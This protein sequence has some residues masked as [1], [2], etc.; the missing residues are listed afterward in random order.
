MPA[1]PDAFVCGLCCRSA[2]S[3]LAGVLHDPMVQHDNAG[4]PAN[5]SS[6]PQPKKRRTVGQPRQND[7]KAPEPTIFLAR[8]YD[9]VNDTKT[10]M[11]IHWSTIGGA[12]A[13]T[14]VDNMLLEKQWLPKFYKHSNF[15]S[16]VR[17]LNQYQFRKVEPRRWSFAHESFIKNR[18]DLL[19]QITRKRKDNDSAKQNSSKRDE[20]VS[21]L[22]ACVKQLSET[23]SRVRE[24]QAEMQTQLK[25]LTEK[26]GGPST[27]Q[28]AEVK[29]QENEST[30]GMPPPDLG[31]S[32][33]NPQPG[34]V[35]FA[36]VDIP[37]DIDGFLS[38]AKQI[39]DE[40]PPPP[41]PPHQNQHQHQQ[42]QQQ[43]RRQNAPPPPAVRTAPREHPLQMP[44]PSTLFQASH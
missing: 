33:L 24:Q 41:P 36:D 30:M 44:R 26:I 13:F 8:L 18:P 37:A 5:G 27:G 19:V 43:Q 1:V 23:L 29:K 42:R 17:Q 11:A 6:E 15:T 14:I 32:L 4:G 2:F 7:K 12:S 40:Q 38:S 10:D 28:L 35:E 34:V 9:M 22:E 25:N 3:A 31:W 16:F 20:R 39:D 21:K